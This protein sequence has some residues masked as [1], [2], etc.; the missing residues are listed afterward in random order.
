MI[1]TGASSATSVAHASFSLPGGH[2]SH[3]AVRVS[4]MLLKL[5]RKHHGVATT[6]TAVMG[7]QTFSQTVTVKIF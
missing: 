4:P 6:F 2:T 5:I 3:L 1:L 7:G